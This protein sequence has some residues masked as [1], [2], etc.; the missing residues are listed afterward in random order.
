MG[1]VSAKLDIDDAGYKGT[2]NYILKIAKYITSSNPTYS[3]NQYTITSNVLLST[4]T[5]TPTKTSTPSPTQTST[6]TPTLTS[7]PVATNLL[8]NFD[9]EEASIETE[10]L[11]TS[12]AEPSASIKTLKPEI[13]TL[14][15]SE[16]I[17]RK[18]L[19]F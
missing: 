18:S 9:N 10:I 15:A 14:S 13:K 3:T 4:P 12:S 17:F 19:L 2:G 1:T 11:G 6:P 5:P 8:V 16:N 7:V